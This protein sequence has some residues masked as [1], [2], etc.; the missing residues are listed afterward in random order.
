MKGTAIIHIDCFDKVCAKAAAAFFCETHRRV[1]MR[2]VRA[3]E[4][5]LLTGLETEVD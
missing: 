3:H 2:F 5:A 4:N 1:P